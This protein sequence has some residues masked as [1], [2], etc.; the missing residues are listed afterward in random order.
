MKPAVLLT[1]L[2]ATLGTPALAQSSLG[3]TGAVLSFGQD[4]GTGAGA[5]GTVAGDFAIT[6]HH[7][8]QFDLGLEETR[9][10]TIGTAGAHLYMTPQAGQKYGIFA[11]V[12]DMDGRS[13]TYGLLGAEGIFAVA[14][15]T[16]LEVRGGVGVA[17]QSSLDFLFVEGDLYHDLTDDLSVHGGLTLAEFDEIGLS[18]T[19]YEA[20]LG[21]TYKPEGQPWGVFAEVARD[22]LHGLTGDAPVTSVRVGVSFEFGN[23]RRGGPASRPFRAPDPVGSLLRRDMF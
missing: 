16:A 23:T 7:G 15:R 19:G 9:A 18:A 22:G 2:A 14:P 3:L 20:R 12:G 4:D 6:E 17:S 11:A 13:A 21:V 10:G 1:V 8:I 5:F